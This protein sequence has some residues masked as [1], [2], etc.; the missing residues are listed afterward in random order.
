MPVDEV[1]LNFLRRHAPHTEDKWLIVESDPDAKYHSVWEIDCTNLEPLV[2]FPPTRPTM[3][4]PVS[5]A[6]S[7][8]ITVD[9]SFHRFVHERED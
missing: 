5:E 1:T 3:S 7:L 4:I 2:A 6:A 8:N 9:P